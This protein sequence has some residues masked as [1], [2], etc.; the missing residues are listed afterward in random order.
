MDELKVEVRVKDSF[1][2][3]PA[4]SRLMWAG[5]VERMGDEKLAKRAD[6][7][8]VEC[9]RMRGRPRMRREVCV[10]TDLGRV[11]GE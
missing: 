6:A 8:K 5:H 1:K 7:Q 9:K 10:K 4:R 3:K 11:G 2:M